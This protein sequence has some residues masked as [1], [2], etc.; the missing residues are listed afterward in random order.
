MRPAEPSSILHV[1]SGCSSDQTF[2][3]Y[4]K[5]SSKNAVAAASAA[6]ASTGTALII[7]YQQLQ[8]Q[9]S[10][11]MLTLNKIITVGIYN[12]A[13]NKLITNI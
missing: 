2:L 3:K 9:W 10:Q 7:Q 11:L 1:H 5:H 13:I 12:N 6:K 4:T 8:Q